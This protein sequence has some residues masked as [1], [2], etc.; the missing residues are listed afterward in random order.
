MKWKSLTSKLLSSLSPKEREESIIYLD[1]KR[2]P[3]GQEFSLLEKSMEFPVPVVVAF[4][5]LEPEFNWTHRARYLI[6]D[7]DGNILDSFDADRPPFLTSTSPTLRLVHRGSMAPSWS[8]VT[9][10]ELTP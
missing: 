6:L 8:A 7:G 2:I 5:D 1:I 4:V 10:E 3:A 9:S